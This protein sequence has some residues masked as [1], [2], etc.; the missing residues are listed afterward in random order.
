MPLMPLCATDWAGVAILFAA[1]IGI[2]MG[3]TFLMVML[4]LSTERVVAERAYARTLL[5]RP[6]EL[7]LPNEIT[8]ADAAALANGP[9]LNHANAVFVH[10]LSDEIP[11]AAP[12]RE[13][14]RRTRVLTLLH[15]VTETNAAPVTPIVEPRIPAARSVIATV[16]ET[17]RRRLAELLALVHQRPG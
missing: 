11:Q 16:D 7:L 5:L 8:S 1:A 6:F 13:E 15:R 4:Y 14:Q 3:V 12:V 17:R 2:V 9:Q 10:N